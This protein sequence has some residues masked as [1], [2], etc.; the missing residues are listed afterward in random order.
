MNERSL[1]FVPFTTPQN[2]PVADGDT[3]SK[4]AYAPLREK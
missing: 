4:V 2:G 1:A 3:T